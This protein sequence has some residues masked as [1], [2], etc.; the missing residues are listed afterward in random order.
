MSSLQDVQYDDLQEDQPVWY[1]ATT[2]P[3]GPAAED[4]RRAVAKRVRIF[5]HNRSR[6][7]PIFEA[8]CMLG[9]TERDDDVLHFIVTVI[10]ELRRQNH[11]GK[12]LEVLVPTC[13]RRPAVA[14]AIADHL[15][16]RK[17]T[18]LLLPWLKYVQ[19]NLES[20]PEDRL[21]LDETR[22]LL[23]FM[24]VLIL[25]GGAVDADAV[26]GLRAAS[27]IAEWVRSIDSTRARSNQTWR[28]RVYLRTELPDG[29]E[30]TSPVAY[31]LNALLTKSESSIQIA[32]IDTEDGE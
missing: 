12:L 32:S 21:V 2:S 26:F 9:G 19:A 30:R 17:L 20:N 3:K 16:P 23:E 5:D 15:G 14:S 22:N 24:L 10:D 7:M 28:S 27:H 13:W 8:A 18:R 25:S 29:Y 6:F 4:V 11:G 31:A 1:N